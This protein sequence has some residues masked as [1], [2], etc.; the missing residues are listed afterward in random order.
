M[1]I[2]AGAWLHC[3]YSISEFYKVSVTNVFD[4]FLDLKIQR[5]LHDLSNPYK[6]WN[7]IAALQGDK[8]PG[9]DVFLLE[10]MQCSISR[11]KIFKIQDI[12]SH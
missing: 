12:F 6:K 2:F 3:Y 10:I 9:Y 5:N 1:A 11:L 7:Q 8:I 4:D